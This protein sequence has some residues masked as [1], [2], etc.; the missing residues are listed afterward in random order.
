MAASSVKH[1]MAEACRNFLLLLLQLTLLSIV[2]AVKF[3]GD[4]SPL[5]YMP[6]M[7]A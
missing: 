5:L 4:C 3:L 7:E 2:M 6:D 1:M